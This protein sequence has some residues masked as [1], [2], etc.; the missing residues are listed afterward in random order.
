MAR[1]IVI[2]SS[3]PTATQDQLFEGAKKV[4]ASLGLG[5]EWMNSWWI[6][7]TDKVFCE[8]EAPNADA[9]RASLEAVKDLFPIEALYEVQWIDPAWWKA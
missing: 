2:H 9:I 3:P 5:T 4:L 6:P 7:E 8:W 1:F